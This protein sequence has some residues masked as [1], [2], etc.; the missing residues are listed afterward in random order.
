MNYKHERTIATRR[1]LAEH[2]A[3]GYGCYWLIRE[4]IAAQGGAAPIS[5][6]DLLAAEAKVDAVTMHS[7]ALDYGLFGVEGETLTDR[8]KIAD[9]ERAIAA[10][11]ARWAK[12]QRKPVKKQKP[13]P[14]TK[15]EPIATIDTEEQ[16]PRY[17]NFVKWAQTETPYLAN[18]QHITQLTPAEFFTLV[19]K[20][21]ANRLADT[22]RDLENRKDKRKQYVSLYRTLLNWCK[23]GNNNSNGGGRNT[24]M[25]NAKAG[26]AERMSGAVQ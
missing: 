12:K 19:N 15:P 16:D 26:I 10:A 11:A 3:T 2:G 23:N 25:D 17:I 6:C 18:P 5:V 4:E 13:E 21:G 24:A 7:V 1:L 9:C 22:M 14:S 8:E 20:F